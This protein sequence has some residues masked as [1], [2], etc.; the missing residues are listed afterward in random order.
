MTEKTTLELAQAVDPRFGTVVLAGEVIGL[1][2]IDAFAAYRRQ[3]E[4]ER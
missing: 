1:K 2:A 4:G 3:V